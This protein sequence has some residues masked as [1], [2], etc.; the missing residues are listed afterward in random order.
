MGPGEADL[1]DQQLRGGVVALPE[2]RAHDLRQ[3]GGADGGQGGRALGRHP[4]GRRPGDGDPHRS[5]QAAQLPGGVDG[6]ILRPL[7]WR[8][9]RR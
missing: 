6:G 4:G 9:R 2:H 3:G 5:G 1:P 8:R 7:F